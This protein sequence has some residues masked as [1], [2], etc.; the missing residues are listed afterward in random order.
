MMG[1]YGI[2][3]GFGP[4]GWLAAIGIVVLAVGV[5]VLIAWLAGRLAP[6]AET[7][8]QTGRPTDLD[9]VE[10]LR[11]R[12]ARGEITRDEFQAASQVLEDRR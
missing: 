9:A 5:V 6:A 11:M 3:L 1:G 2:G 4:G 10:L 7:R 8:H 12:F